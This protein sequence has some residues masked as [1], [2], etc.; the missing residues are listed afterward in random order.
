[1]PEESKTPLTEE[2]KIAKKVKI[3]RILSRILMIVGTL[4]III[5]IVLVLLTRENIDT[6]TTINTQELRSKLKQIIS[7]E[8]KYYAKN[9]KYVEIRYLS[10]QKELPT[11]DPK[12]D[13]NFKYRFD[14]ETEIAT[15]IEKDASHDVNGDDDGNDGLTLSVSW[16]AGK[17]PNSDFFWTENDLANFEARRTE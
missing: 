17:T 1:M 7:L 3:R 2:E 5:F 8:K 14:P 10:L 11:Y 9:E 15:G 12:I 6:Q 13:G 16:E 4:L